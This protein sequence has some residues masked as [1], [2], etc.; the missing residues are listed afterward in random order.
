MQPTSNPRLVAE[1]MLI[2]NGVLEAFSIGTLPMDAAG[3]RELASWVRQSFVS[4]GS[5]A[6]RAVRDAAPLELQG[7]AE[8]VLHDRRVVSWAAADLVGLSSYAACQGLLR[9]LRHRAH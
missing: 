8:N 6:L 1:Q 5:P 7:I 9:R 3:Y 4:M 2:A